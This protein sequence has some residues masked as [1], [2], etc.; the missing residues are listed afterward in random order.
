MTKKASYI[1][2]AYYMKLP[3]AL[4][5]FYTMK[6]GRDLSENTLSDFQSSCLSAQK[7]VCVSVCVFCVACRSE[8][9]PFDA[10]ENVV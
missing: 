8:K 7:V 4:N 3:I 10:H 6:N 1:N 5:I 9:L 2:L